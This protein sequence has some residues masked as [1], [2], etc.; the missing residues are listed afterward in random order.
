MPLSFRMPCWELFEAQSG[1]YRAETL[2]DAPR[3]AIE[4]AMKFG[5]ERWLRPGDAFVGM[6]GFGASA[7]ADVLY[8]HFGITAENDRRG[9]SRAGRQVAAFSRRGSVRS[10]RGPARRQGP[11]PW[12]RLPCR[13]I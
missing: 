11:V 13:S 5:W 1:E 9:C 3:V 2:G 12:A 8:A 6:E 4:A 7:T 10:V